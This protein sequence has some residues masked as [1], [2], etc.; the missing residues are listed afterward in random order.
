MLYKSLRIVLKLLQFLLNF[1]SIR[2]CL[3]LTSSGFLDISKRVTEASACFSLMVPVVT[4][5]EP[6][7]LVLALTTRHVRAALGLNRNLAFMVR[8]AISVALT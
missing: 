6:A 2:Q 4:K 5:A 8:H 7:E 1:V 3:I